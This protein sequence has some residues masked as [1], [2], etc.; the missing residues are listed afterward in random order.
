[1]GIPAQRDVERSRAALSTWFAQVLGADGPV[2]LG[3][4]R[5]PGATGF[6][7][8]TLIVDL[9]FSRGG[10]RVEESYVVRVAPTGYTLFPDAA[11]DVQYEVLRALAEKTSVPVP[12]VHWYEKDIDVLGAPFFVMEE[13]RGAVPPDNPPYHVAGWLHDV[14]PEV[15]E[16][17]WWG[18]IDT[19]ADVHAVDWRDLGVR[20]LDKPELGEPGLPQQLAYYTGFLE[21]IEAHEPVPVAR[22]ALDW[23]LAH[24]PEP[25]DLVLCWGD[26]RVGNVMYDEDGRRV[27]VLD[28]EMVGLGAPSQDVAW[29]MLLDRHHSEGCGVPRLEGFPTAAQTAARYEE[30]TGRTLRALDYY[31][32]FAAF[33]FCVIMGRLALIFKDWGLLQPDDGMAQDN[34]AT[35]LT[36]TILSERGAVRPK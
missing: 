36:E 3:E 24:P 13:V 27:A 7:N 29:A 26:A 8:E 1:M 5:G 21:S 10:A 4:F 23:L 28:W 18:C 17:I 22:R 32:V 19:I 15:R 11:F 34:T 33:R 35:R 20:H 12:A 31:E 14:A 9:A 25:E 30:R 6:S 16:R 2:E